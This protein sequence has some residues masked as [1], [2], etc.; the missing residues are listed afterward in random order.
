MT[1]PLTTLYPDAPDYA[2]E[3]YDMFVATQSGKSAKINDP[4]AWRIFALIVR[5]PKKNPYSWLCN[6]AGTRNEWA[7]KVLIAAIGDEVPGG[8]AVLEAGLKMGDRD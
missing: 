5:P 8:R 7:I 4:E 1:H 2:Q 6:V 3:A